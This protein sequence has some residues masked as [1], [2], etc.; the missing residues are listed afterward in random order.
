VKAGIIGMGPLG[1]AQERWLGADVHVTYDP[2]HDNEYPAGRLAECDFVIVCAP[3]EEVE[4]AVRNVPFARPVLLRTTVPPGT[5]EKFD[6]A[7]YCPDFIT[8]P[9]T[10]NWRDPDDVPFLILG[11][12][13][14]L[15]MK[16]RKWLTPRFPG[17]ILRCSSR[18]AELVKYADSAFLAAKVTFANEMARIACAY[19]VDWRDVELLWSTDPRTGYTH[20]SVTE[21]GGF[22]G[23]FEKDLADIIYAASL[24]DYNAEFLMAVEEA[25][26]RFRQ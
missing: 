23:S 2:E 16:F 4:P 14:S 6:H 26:A 10:G 3:A 18:V 9:S 22:S 17:A 7:V 19:G 12:E 11:G 5:T 13:G 25:N 21:T 8:D 15:T 20:T 1:L 24:G